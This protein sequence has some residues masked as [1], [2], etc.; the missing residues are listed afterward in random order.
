MDLVAQDVMTGDISDGFDRD[1]LFVE[2]D[3]VA[4]HYLL[5]CLTDMVYP[6]IDS[7]FLVLLSLRV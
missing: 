6:R 2:L 7:S 3:L 4:F 1:S 5:D